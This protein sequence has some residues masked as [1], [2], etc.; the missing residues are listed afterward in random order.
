[1]NE[2]YRVYG[3]E[4]SY[5]TMKARAAFRAKRLFIEELLATPRVYAEVILPRV[6]MAFIPVVVTPEDET[7]QDT[8]D[9]ID[10]LE[11]RHR[12]PALFPPTP[13]QRVAAYLW[14]LYCDEFL[15]I[16]AL[17]YRW[18]FEE[19]ERKARADFAAFNGNAEKANRFADAVKSFTRGPCGVNDRTAPAI[20]A[21][22]ADLLARLEAHFAVHSFLLG[23]RPSLADCSLMGP[24]YA[25]L[26]QDAVPGR[27]LRERAPRTCQW[28]ERMNRP[29]VNAY[30]EWFAGDA[31][32]PTM[33][34]LLELIGRD[35]AQ[36]VL[37]TVRDFEKWADGNAKAGAEPPRITGMHT[38]HLRDT[39][40]ERVTSAYTL[41]MLQRPLAAYATLTNAE[42]ATVDRT[43][44]GTGCE[45]VLAY[46]PRHQLGKERF[47]LIF[48]P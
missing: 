44:A 22:V 7:W 28:V 5:F 32:S 47:K 25:H 1:M 13:M 34:S 4:I 38:T 46:R 26:Y 19:S 31:L 3:A 29:D 33:R 30:G 36:V 40:I 35:A 11:E 12:E 39:E 6:G 2:P 48:Q 14:E 24:M 8:S 17:H 21:H 15:I 42:R 16:P 37:D 18:S 27:L 23:E 10:A 41:W 45:Q 20:E 9:I 43:V